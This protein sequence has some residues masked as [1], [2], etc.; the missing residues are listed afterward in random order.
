MSRLTK[1]DIANM[2][3]NYSIKNWKSVCSDDERAE[4]IAA[5]TDDIDAIEGFIEGLNDDLTACPDD[6]EAAEL[7]ALVKTLKF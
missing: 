7:L 6:T 4:A 2:M 5:Y 3:I 1:Q